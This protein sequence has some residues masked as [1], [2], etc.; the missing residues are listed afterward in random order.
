MESTTETYRKCRGS[1]EWSEEDSVY[2]GKLISGMR[3]GDLIT[4]EADDRSD[5]QHE[6]EDSVDYYFEFLAELLN[7][8][9]R[10]AQQ[11]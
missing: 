1:I 9:E 10:V 2:H 6:F 4:Y 3:S 11:V 5:L 7:E 8:P